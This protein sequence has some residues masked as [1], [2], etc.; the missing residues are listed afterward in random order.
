MATNLTG[1]K[2]YIYIRE[3]LSWKKAEEYSINDHKQYILIEQNSTWEDARSYCRV[4]HTD[5]AVIEKDEE[6]RNVTS[7]TRGHTVWIGLYREPW[8]WS[9]GSNSSFRRWQTAEPSNSFGIEHCA[10]NNLDHQWGDRDCGVLL[11]FICQG[12]SGGGGN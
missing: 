6:N 3:H 2:T 11:P 10:V 12:V 7:V 1:Q 8:M 4:N 5:L 9:D